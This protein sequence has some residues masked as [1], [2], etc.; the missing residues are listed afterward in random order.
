MRQL[1]PKYGIRFMNLGYWPSKGSK[2]GD[3][4]MS[5]LIHQNTFDYDPNTPHYY[6]YERALKSLDSYPDL[7]GLHI[8][9]VGSGLG[10][11]VE[12]IKRA[13]PM[14]ESVRGVDKCAIPGSW[15]TSGDAHHLPFDDNCFDL[16]INVESSHLYSNCEQFFRE[17]R[18]VL[19]QSGQLCWIDLRYKSQVDETRKQAARAQLIEERWDDV[20]ENVLLGIQRTAARYDQILNMT[21]WFVRM[22]SSSLRATYCAPGTHTYARFSTGEKGYYAA[23]W[24]RS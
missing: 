2:T 8:L 17:C 12:W 24:R 19:K 5:N 13:H 21:P 6:L 11:G 18:R 14:V 16:V 9:E 7:S 4:A 3:E 20:T 10:Y 1:S 23:V 15:V 22:F